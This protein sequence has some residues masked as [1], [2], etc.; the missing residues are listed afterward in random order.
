MKVLLRN[1]Q[2]GLF[3]AGPEQWTE[4]QCV[5]TDFEGPDRALDQVSESNL[6]AVE[7]VIH[8]EDTCFDI[9]LKIV[10]PAA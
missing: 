1:I 2:T 8:F 5:A 7:V 9:P 6:E 10:S 3:Y 4:D